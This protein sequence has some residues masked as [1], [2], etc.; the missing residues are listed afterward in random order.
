MTEQVSQ[1]VAFTLIGKNAFEA[2]TH[3]YI[4]KFTRFMRMP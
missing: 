2:E 1:K 4:W 3:D